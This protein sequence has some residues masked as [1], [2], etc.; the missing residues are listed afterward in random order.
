MKELK[1]V[2]ITLLWTRRSQTRACI[3]RGTE[4]TA[5]TSTRYRVTDDWSPAWWEIRA[6]AVAY[7]YYI[8]ADTSHLE[9]LIHY[10]SWIQLW[11]WHQVSELISP[12]KYDTDTNLGE[13]SK[14]SPGAWRWMLGS[15]WKGWTCEHEKFCG[16]NRRPN[17]YGVFEVE[18]VRVQLSTSSQA[19]LH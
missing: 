2:K 11:V 17:W 3:A 12:C 10:N 8:S 16:F 7:I 4:I 14:N 1:N 18:T 15:W 19:L 9:W 5:Q 13:M 6:A